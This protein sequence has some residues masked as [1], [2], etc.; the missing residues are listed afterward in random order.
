MAPC[1]GALL[2]LLFS[3]VLLSSAAG[4]SYCCLVLDVCL[5]FMASTLPPTASSQTLYS[6]LD[7]NLRPE[8]T[9]NVKA[10]Q[11]IVVYAGFNGGASP[12]AV[13]SGRAHLD[14]IVTATDASQHAVQCTVG[15]QCRFLAFAL[16]LFGLPQH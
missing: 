15:P 8:N 6:A 1:F 12:S 14:F 9:L 2:A 11:T 3:Q 5:R 13:G 4:Q 16:A 10:E 7:P